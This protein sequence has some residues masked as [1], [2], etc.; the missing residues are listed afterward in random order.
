MY[1]VGR[2]SP[3]ANSPWPPPKPS[4]SRL[5]QTDPQSSSQEERPPQRHKA[6]WSTL[7]PT[8]TFHILTKN[9]GN[10]HHQNGI[11]VLENL[12]GTSRFVGGAIFGNFL[13]IVGTYSVNFSH[14]HPKPKA[15]TGSRVDLAANRDRERVHFGHHLF[16]A[17]ASLQGYL[18]HKK[19]RPPR[20]GHHL[21]SHQPSGQNQIAC[22][23]S[24]I[25]SGAR[26]NPATQGTNRGD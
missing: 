20:T 21:V 1:A 25:C 6:P 17:Q 23:R 2:S 16:R 18:A 3:V 11:P 14:F 26:Q 9:S 24:F 10:L 12:K 5:L 19:Q 22:F 13:H 4:G 8:S 15:G 7:C